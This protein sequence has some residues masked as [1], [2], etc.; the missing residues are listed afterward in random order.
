MLFGDLVAL[1]C[2]WPK[3]SR[4]FI[5]FENSDFETEYSVEEAVRRFGNCRVVYFV[6]DF[7]VL[8]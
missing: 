1:N 6:D 7:V 8:R 2:G 4:I 3:E 5:S